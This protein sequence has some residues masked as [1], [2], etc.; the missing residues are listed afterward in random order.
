MERGSVWEIAKWCQSTNRAQQLFPA[1]HLLVHF[2]QVPI[3]LCS[4]RLTVCHSLILGHS[5]VKSAT[6]VLHCH[7]VASSLHRADGKPDALRPYVCRPCRVAS[8]ETSHG[9]IIIIT[10]HSS[11]S[12]IPAINPTSLTMIIRIPTQ[13]FNTSR[14]DI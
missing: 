3:S 13:P 5:N 9:L 4:L 10:K 11:L 2:P 1:T 12:H 8:R 7:L 6:E 14:N